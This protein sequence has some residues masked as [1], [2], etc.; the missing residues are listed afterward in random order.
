METDR[1]I[2]HVDDIVGQ[3]PRVICGQIVTAALDEEN[4]TAELGLQ[5]F[6]CTHVG[7][8][9][10]ANSG[11]RTATGFDG[12]DTFSGEGSVLDQELLVFAG[13]NIVCN[14]R[15]RQLESCRNEAASIHDEKARPGEKSC[16]VCEEKFSIGLV[17]FVWQGSAI[18]S[19]GEYMMFSRCMASAVGNGRSYEISRVGQAFSL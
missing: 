18:K 14:S 2:N 1:D 12:Q 15:C 3:F 5:S 19:W 7:A 4:L 10:L 13:E 17:P 11:M 16:G 8:D 9:V 6:K